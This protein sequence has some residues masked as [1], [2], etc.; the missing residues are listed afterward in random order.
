M[1]NKMKEVFLLND[2]SKVCV[3]KN[4][5][6]NFLVKNLCGVSFTK[7]DIDLHEEYTDKYSIIHVNGTFYL[8]DKDLKS[9]MLDFKWIANADENDEIKIYSFKNSEELFK[10][11]NN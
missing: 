8:L 6:K 4:E 3:P 10:W 1:K 9:V 5:L 7:T 11:I 2:D